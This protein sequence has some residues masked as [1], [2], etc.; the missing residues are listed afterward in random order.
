MAEPLMK[1]TVALAFVASMIPL[2]LVGLLPEIV[3]VFAP[4]V[5][6]PTVAA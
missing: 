4:T 6:V 2:V 5:N 1:A 3:K